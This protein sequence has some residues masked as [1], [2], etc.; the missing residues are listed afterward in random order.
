MTTK[1]LFSSRS[2]LKK[3]T[4]NT[5]F[6][7]TF[8]FFLKC[9][10]SGKLKAQPREVTKHRRFGS[11]LKVDKEKL[12]D[13]A[14]KGFKP[15]RKMMT[16]L[17]VI[18]IVI[19]AFS[20]YRGISEEWAS[21]VANA[22]ITIN[23]IL[24]GF[25]ILGITVFSKRSYTETMF[26]K[27][28]EESATEFA[29]HVEGI[30]ESLDKTS[31]KGLEEKFISSLFYPFVD[32]I[33]LRES[34]LRSMQL[35]LVSIGSALCLFG[36]NTDVL[37]NPFLNFFFRIAYCISISMFLL[38]TYFIMYGVRS[39]LEKSM[40]FNVEKQFE[41]AESVFEKKIKYLEK[42]LKKTKEKAQSK[43]T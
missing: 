19:S 27:S 30:L 41:I 42:K 4:K 5:I 12:I 1:T 38:G 2:E 39:I 13:K 18:G 10:K 15:S 21:E 8:S 34:F 3:Q 9:E 37:S 11:V 22:L 32:V 23:G 33:L 7:L 28:V 31:M 6:Y 29:S 17:I 25:T 16:L 40:G 14:L 43:Q 20:T 26:R 24:L 36:I 35:L